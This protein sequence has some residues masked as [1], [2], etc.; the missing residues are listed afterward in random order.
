MNRQ[1]Q[2]DFIRLLLRILPVAVSLIPVTVFS[3]GRTTDVVTLKNG[4]IL[5]GTLRTFPDSNKIGIETQCQSCWVFDTSEVAS[6]DYNI[7]FNGVWQTDNLSP[8]RTSGYVNITE[9]GLL[10]GSGDNEKNTIFSVM[11]TNGYR[12]RNRLYGGLGLGLE[13][14]EQTQLPLFAEARYAFTNRNV[15]PVLILK[16]GYSFML[17]DPPD[18][19][20]FTYEGKGGY[21]WAAGMGVHFRLNHHNILSVSMSYRYQDNTVVHTDPWYRD[22][23]WVTKKY[24]RMSFSIGIIFD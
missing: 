23:T 2:P 7:S 12:Y 10:F 15:T 4:S 24:N 19:D 16:G 8:A 9:A 13:F 18:T 1:K 14:F 5:R 22:K 17:E 20:W 3:Q 6:V 21:L 11:M